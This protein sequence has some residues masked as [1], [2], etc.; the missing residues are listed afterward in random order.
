VNPRV[1]A[2]LA[3]VV[4]LALGTAALVYP[5]RVMG[6]LGFSVQN[7]SHAAATLGEVRATYGGIFVV[8]GIYTLLASA[9]PSLH[10]G[11]LVFLGLLWLGAL[12]GRLFGVSVDG[13]PGL[14]GWLS[15]AFELVVGGTLLLA[16]QTAESPSRAAVAPA[17][18]TP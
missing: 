10:R 2:A 12:A 18:P 17:T 13:N 15:A 3:G 14:P 11:R 4:T 8:L 9:N 1:A 6:L 16:A 5:E 7:A